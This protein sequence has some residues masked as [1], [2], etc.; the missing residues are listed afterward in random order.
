M[1]SQPIRC[2][3]GANLLRGLPE[4]ERF[5]L[6]EHIRDQHVVVAAERIQRLREGDQIRG[7]EPRSLVD[8]L[9]ERVLAVGARLSPVDWAGV[10]LHALAVERYLLAVALHGELLQV[11]WE[12]LQVLL[13]GKNRDRL[14][15]EEVV[16]PD[17]EQALEDWEIALERRGAEMLVHLV[18]TGKHLAES[19]RA[20][21][22]HRGEPDR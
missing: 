19:V 9:V 14:G 4:R 3:F 15:A 13:I 10:V 2:S 18:E 16:V 12:A 11:R 1:R 6:R 22:Q 8:P 20:N 17:G 21:R 5:R 7:Y